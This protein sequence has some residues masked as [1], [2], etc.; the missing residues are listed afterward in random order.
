MRARD[1]YIVK[2]NS[3][4]NKITSRGDAGYILPSTTDFG[5]YAKITVLQQAG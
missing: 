1:Q 5:N 4:T 2:H 3:Q